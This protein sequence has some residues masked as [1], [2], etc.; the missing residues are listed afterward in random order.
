[1]Q[2]FRLLTTLALCGISAFA[3]NVT[4]VVIP[5]VRVFPESITSMS[6]GTLIIGSLGLGSVFR[7]AVGQG[8]AQEWIK[9]ASFCR[10]IR[11]DGDH[12]VQRLLHNLRINRIR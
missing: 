11:L 10:Q 3:A 2:P 4:E 12:V 6:D 9:P 7:A 8:T 5:G 1:M